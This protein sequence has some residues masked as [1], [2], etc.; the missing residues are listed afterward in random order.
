MVQT[1]VARP[2]VLLEDDSNDWAVQLGAYERYTSAQ[3]VLAAAAGILGAGDS[4][5]N[6]AIDSTTVANGSSL[7]RARFIDLN[8][9][10]SREICETLTKRGVNCFRLSPERK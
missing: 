2:P 3:R 4:A 6:S 9:I 10:Q 1:R 7:Y 8:S 5:Y